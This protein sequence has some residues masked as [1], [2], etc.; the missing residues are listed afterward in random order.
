VHKVHGN[1]R[2]EGLPVG[3]IDSNKWPKLWR[4]PSPDPE[5]PGKLNQF[6]ENKPVDPEVLAAAGVK[7]FNIDPTGYNY[8]KIST[9]PW[10][11]A[12]N[13]KLDSRLAKI[14]EDLGF[15]Y[16]DVIVVNKFYPSFWDE[17]YHGNSTIRYIVDGTGYFDLRDVNNEWVR[18][19]VKKGDFMIWPAGIYHRFSVDE[20]NFII[21]M[22]LFKGSPLWNSFPRDTHICTEDDTVRQEY[23]DNVLCC[24]DPDLQRCPNGRLSPKSRK[25]RMPKQKVKKSKKS[26]STSKKSNK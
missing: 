18:M 26:K 23:I 21:A 4:L 13:I 22:R 15:S 10:E 8:P 16:A 12:S 25:C 24:N 14:R 20:N 2:C 9:V 1:S 3:T 5:Y 17:H 7:Y 11:P 6:D 19:S